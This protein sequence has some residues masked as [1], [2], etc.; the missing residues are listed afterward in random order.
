MASCV[1]GQV[2]SEE[3]GNRYLVTKGKTTQNRGSNKLK[4]EIKRNQVWKHRDSHVGQIHSEDSQGPRSG[5]VESLPCINNTECKQ[6]TSRVDHQLSIPSTS[7]WTK[8]MFHVDQLLFLLVENAGLL[9]GL[10][11]V[12]GMIIHSYGS[13]PTNQ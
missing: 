12:A 3:I 4:I 11:G 1:Q 7:N 6:A 8:G 13:F 5:A 2:R 10:L 9:D